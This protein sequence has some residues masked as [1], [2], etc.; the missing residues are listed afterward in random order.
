M[1]ASDKQTGIVLVTVLLF[2]TVLSLLVLTQMQL[3]FL[4][5]KSIN[6]RNEQ[7]Q[8]FFQFEKD[9]KKLAEIITSSTQHACVI[10]AMDANAV[11]R[12]LKTKQA[13]I[14]THE[15]QQFYYLV[16]DLG[17]FPCI[18]TVVDNII[19][20]TSHL[21][22]SMLSANQQAG[23]LQLRIARLAQLANCEC[24]EPILIR[25]RLLSWRYLSNN[26]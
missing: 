2:I 19:Y 21:R 15:K 13:C 4:D 25:S 8:A 9:A 23:I 17:Q 20:S 7:H 26:L 11:I 14:S 3:V 6:Q 16:E 12:V 22:I 1:T 5:Y 24:N 18:Q 10:P